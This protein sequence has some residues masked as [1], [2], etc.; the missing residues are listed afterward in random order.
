MAN[1]CRCDTFFSVDAIVSS[2]CVCVWCCVSLWPQHCSLK[3][4][5]Q[6]SN[7]LLSSEYSTV[8]G[9]SMCCIYCHCRGINLIHERLH[10]SSYDHRNLRDYLHRGDQLFSVEFLW[11]E[12]ILMK[13]ELSSSNKESHQRVISL[14]YSTML[15]NIVQDVNWAFDVSLFVEVIFLQYEDLMLSLCKY[16]CKLNISGCWTVAWTK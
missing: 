3:L 2:L 11:Y 12:C 6:P 7:D 1:I 16:H 9:G 5:L 13:E 4:T 10:F 14:N 15:L 8:M